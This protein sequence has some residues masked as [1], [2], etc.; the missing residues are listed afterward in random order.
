MIERL[1]GEF[2]R[3]YTQAIMDLT[4]V[5]QYTQS[6]FKY[7]H[8][9]FNYKNSMELLKCCLENREKI[10]DKWNGF[11]RY[12]AQKQGFEYYD[13]KQKEKMLSS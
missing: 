8:K 9:S 10:R 5:F 11:I 13:P 4:E 7:H 2:N 6:D 1:S 12:N 3:G